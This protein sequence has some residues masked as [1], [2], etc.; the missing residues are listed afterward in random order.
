MIITGLLRLGAKFCTL[1]YYMALM[2][3]AL[4]CVVMQSPEMF[5]KFSTS[6]TAHPMLIGP[7]GLL[8]VILEMKL[9]FTAQSC[10]GVFLIIMRIIVA[11]EMYL[12]A[13]MV[14]IGLYIDEIFVPKGMTTGMEWFTITEGIHYFGIYALGLAAAVFI[15]HNL[16]HFAVT[17]FF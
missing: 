3:F 8:I 12:A 14:F 16:I 4:F 2:G 1:L 6:I 17:I 7:V 11:V 13:I 9:D 15:V 5:D 10:G